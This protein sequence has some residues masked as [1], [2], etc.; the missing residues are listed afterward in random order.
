MIYI[1]EDKAEKLPGLTSLFI[2]FDF[3]QLIVDELKLLETKWYNSKECY[4]EV[5]LTDLSKL[6]DILSKI[7]TI[8]LSLLKDQ[9]TK[10]NNKIQTKKFKTKPYE[11]QIDGITYGLNH[12]NWLLL[13]DCGL[14]KTLQII[15]LAQ[16]LQKTKGIKH[17]LIV[18]GVNNL[19]SN[20][21]N[22]IQK[23]S[24]LSCTILGE[25]VTKSGR[26]VF[27]SV[28]DRLEQLGKN[29]KE[30]FIITNI[31]TLRDKN[32]I[33]ALL[34]GKNQ[35]DMMCVDE[36]HTCK[37]PKSQQ[38]EHLLKLTKYAYKIGMTGTL[39]MNNPL[40]AYVPLKWI[41]VEHSNYSTFKNF[42][43]QY[44]GQFHNI[45]L[46]FKNLDILKNQ[47]N[48]YSL[49]RKKED[50][51]DL[52]DKVIIE[53]LV[54]MDNKQSTFYNNIKNGIIE[55][56]DKVKISTASLLSMI[57]RLRQATACPSILTSEDIISAKIE[58]TQQ[59]VDEIVAND[60]K[61][62]I[63]S[64]FKETVYTLEKLLKQYKPLVNTGDIEDT[65]IA[66]NV[67]KFQEQSENKVFLATWQKCGTGITLTKASYMIFI[68]TPW[69]DAIFKQACDRIY[70][71]G[72]SKTVFIYNLITKDTIDERV[73]DI[74]ID[75]RA[76]SSY[77]IDD[78]I[79]KDA[80]DSLKKYILELS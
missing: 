13:D 20:W 49:R 59:L 18:C 78:E 7:D 19:K 48:L 79:P 2:T 3:N 64:T 41:G 14:G 22:E 69:T 39:L 62:V 45:F 33:K 27:G 28:K 5:P 6:I 17:C 56:V 10:S 42:Y 12:N 61:V 70:R 36:I 50:V 1:K 4:W 25:K 31:E 54:D 66:D 63:F 52:P 65:V 67:K 75:K 76:L 53:E 68:D 30:F 46:G 8:D 40:D 29:I 26:V 38:G 47:L 74:L 51:L 34:K 58:R 24:S 60:G 32:I 73:R 23:H 44:T 77:L 21:K 55:E 43:C 37:S 16:E 72:T 35:I 57:A 71:I 80:L 11:Y 9:S 15:Y